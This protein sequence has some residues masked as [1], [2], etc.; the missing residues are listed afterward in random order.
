MIA[1]LE[2]GKIEMNVNQS[3]TFVIFNDLFVVYL[4]VKLAFYFIQR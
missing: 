2:S 3:K 1:T 4:F